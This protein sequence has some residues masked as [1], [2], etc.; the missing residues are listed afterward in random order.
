MLRNLEELIVLIHTDVVA[1]R[2]MAFKWRTVREGTYANI[3]NNIA[4]M[5]SCELF[6]LSFFFLLLPL[7]IRTCE[8]NSFMC[9]ICMMNY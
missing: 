9:D 7:L 2:F 3:T 8:N 1:F 4:C 5:C 6:F